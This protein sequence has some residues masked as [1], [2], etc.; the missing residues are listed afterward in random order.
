MVVNSLNRLSSD[1]ISII[2]SQSFG[3]MQLTDFYV[4]PDSAETL[5]KVKIKHFLIPYLV[6]NMSAKNIKVVRIVTGC[7]RV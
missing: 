6:N 4:L 5:D 7:M 3:Q 1:L 2:S